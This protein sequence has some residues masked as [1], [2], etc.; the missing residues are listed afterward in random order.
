MQAPRLKSRAVFLVEF[1]GNI[2]GAAVERLDA[3]Q[4]AHLLIEQIKPVA[5]ASAANAEDLAGIDP[6]A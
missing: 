4:R 5:M 1:G 3:L 2:T 6:G